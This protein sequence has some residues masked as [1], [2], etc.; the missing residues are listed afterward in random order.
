[1][2]KSFLLIGG[3]S[4][5]GLVL[6]ERLLEQGH[7][8]T[9]FARDVE[10]TSALEAK[11]ATVIHGDA[12]DETAVQQAVASASEHAPDGLAGIAHLV[13]SIALRPPHATKLEDF[14]QVIATNLTS[15]FLTLKTGGKSMIKS[16][17][18]R[19]VFVSGSYRYT[20]CS[21]G[22][23]LRCDTRSL[24]FHDSPSPAQSTRRSGK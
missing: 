4:D 24:G 19:M 23:T 9:L 6:G 21:D 5:I 13:G 20:P 22:S 14:E 11:G 12:L 18:G 1:M 15:A 8:V 2:S 3:S 17:G 16:G 10:R 7:H